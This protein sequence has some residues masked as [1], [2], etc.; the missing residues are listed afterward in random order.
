[1]A[2][3]G[4]P[5]PRFAIVAK[6]RHRYMMV[7]LVGVLDSYSGEEI[8]EALQ[9]VCTFSQGTPS[10]GVIIRC[11]GLTSLTPSGVGLLLQLV[12]QFEQLTNV[13]LVEMSAKFQGLLRELQVA[14]AFLVCQHVSEAKRYLRA[15]RK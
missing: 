1:M 12:E 10:C 2:K 13:V 7:D 15:N 11:R 4:N 5:N 9:G 8:Q 6:M 14:D 3:K